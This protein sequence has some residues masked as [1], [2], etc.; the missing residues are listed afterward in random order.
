MKEYKIYLN[1]KEIGTSKLEKGDAPMG[2]AFGKLSF[3]D[4]NYGYSQIKNYC[5]E[6]GI[7]LA[8]DFSDDKMISTMTLNKLKVINENGIEIKGIG[9]QITGMD[10]E[11]Y[12]I[13]IFGIAYPFYETEFPNLVKEYEDMLKE[14]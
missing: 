1:E 14:K 10:N 9:N 8:M 4:R 11:E 3:I 7:E 2:V 5:T 12:E 13:S 6:N